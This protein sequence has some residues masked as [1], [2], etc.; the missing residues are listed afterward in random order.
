MNYEELLELVK[1]R[2]SIRRFKLDTVPDETIKKIIEV[3]RWAPSG[4]NHQPWE[5][6]IINNP[7]FKAKIS[8]Y[9]KEQLRLRH[10][11]NAA[12]DPTY[13]LHRAEHK[14]VTEGGDFCVAP[15]FI[16]LVG[17]HRTMRLMPSA[18]QYGTDYLNDTFT[19]GLTCCFLYMQLAAT[20]LGLASQWVSAVQAPYVNFMV[21][22]L[23]GIPK[24]LTIYNMMALGYPASPPRPRLVR[25]LE[26]MVH[27]D[28]CGPTAFRSEAE[29]IEFIKNTRA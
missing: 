22:E 15:V 4:F 7:E 2:R 20:T 26:Q 11:M 24:D 8:E 10:K 6:V 5:F 19:A 18:E 17:D 12:A 29:V 28:F 27:Y 9:C 16:A 25:P 1:S 14:P 3:A 23:I 13:Q 21:K